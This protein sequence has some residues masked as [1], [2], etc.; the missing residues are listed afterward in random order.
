[1]EVASQLWKLGSCRLLLSLLFILGYFAIVVLQ[2]LPYFII[3][4]FNV[5]QIL[6]ASIEVMFILARVKASIAAK[7]ENWSTSVKSLS[8]IKLRSSYRH[9]QFLNDLGLLMVEAHLSSLEYILFVIVD[10]QTC[11]MSSENSL[12]QG[13]SSSLPL[14]CPLD[15]K[16]A[17]V[18]LDSDGCP[19]FILSVFLRLSIVNQIQKFNNSK[20]FSWQC[21]W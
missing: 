4:C 9:L 21:S 12:N 11:Q 5:L 8:V 1:M 10:S 18:S 19:Q 14:E 15:L 13:N 20:M 3:L 7:K 17:P 2:V 6:L 16:H